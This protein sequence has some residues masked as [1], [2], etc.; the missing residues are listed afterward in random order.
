MYACTRESGTPSRGRAKVPEWSRGSCGGPAGVRSCRS[1]FAPPEM[2]PPTR[3]GLSCS[4]SA[5]VRAA[6]A[7]TRSRKPGAK[8][9]IWAS[10]RSRMSN[11][12][13][14]GTWQYAHAVCLPAG[15]RVASKRLCCASRTK[16]RSGCLPS[17]AAR[18][19][20]AISASDAAN[21]NGAGLVRPRVSA[22]GSVRPAHSRA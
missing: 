20:S 7:R 18:S 13:P 14:F 12:D 9:S 5:V 3:L 22:R 4:R 15:A 6:H 17:Q 21:V 19:E 16:G 10:T 1:V 2:S 8:R 11:V